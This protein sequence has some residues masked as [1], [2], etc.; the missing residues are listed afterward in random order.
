M[1]VYE[2]SLL[3]A[4][5]SP[6]LTATDEAMEAGPFPRSADIISLPPVSLRTMKS[7]CLESERRRMSPSRAR[8]RTDNLRDTLK[9]RRDTTQSD[10]WPSPDP[11]LVT[12]APPHSDH[13]PVV[14]ETYLFLTVAGLMMKIM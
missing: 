14:M 4:C 2:A 8:L 1:S 13:G 3:T 9:T 5:H 6:S 7:I 11:P 10:D 12:I